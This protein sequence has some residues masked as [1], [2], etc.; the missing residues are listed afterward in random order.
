[1]KIGFYQDHG[2]EML[3]QLNIY[4]LRDEINRGKDKICFSYTPSDTRGIESCDAVIFYRCYMLNKQLISGLRNQG[5]LI[6]YSNDDLLWEEGVY[7]KGRRS[8]IE[9]YFSISDFFVMPS[10]YIASKLPSGKPIIIRLPGLSRDGYNILSSAQIRAR[11]GDDIKVVIS[12]GHLTPPVIGMLNDIL[13]HL[14]NE[15]SRSSS[16]M[17]R[18]NVTY[19]SNGPDLIK[20]HTNGLV[21]NK[22]PYVSPVSSFY[23]RLLELNPDFILSPM[24]DDEFHRCKSYPKYLE[25][26]ALGSILIASKV[27]P[28]E[29]VIRDGDNGFLASGK[30]ASDI[31]LGTEKR[32]MLEI[33]RKARD[34]IYYNHMMP[35]V[36]SR[37]LSDMRSLIK[38]LESTVSDKRKLARKSLE[39]TRHTPGRSGIF[40]QVS[41]LNKEKVSTPITRGQTIDISFVCLVDELNEIQLYGATYAQI[42]FEPVTFRL[43]HKDRV[44]HA[45]SL[46]SADLLDNSWWSM[47]FPKLLLSNQRLIL[48]IKNTG[49]KPVSFYLGKD[50]LQQEVMIGDRRLDPLAMKIS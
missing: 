7:S 14:H 35:L 26:G 6:G 41:E 19:L 12:K 39:D 44:V 15:I 27:Y 38:K 47:K 42:I 34:D 4:D 40:S 3:N 23:K 1:M 46:T 33:K 36:A 20:S 10:K 11:E 49:S 8:I 48:R 22:I 31:I 5:V 30:K 45:A 43:I 28:Y 9:E 50:S 13:G 32:K 18:V 24:P 2:N 17:F 16:N 37:F 25:A 29:S 21:I